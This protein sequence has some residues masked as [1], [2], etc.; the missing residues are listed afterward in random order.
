MATG[1]PSG[2]ESGGSILEA[3]VPG[4]S[5]IGRPTNPLAKC[6]AVGEPASRTPSELLQ[7]NIFFRSVQVRSVVGPTYPLAKC[8]AVGELASR[9]PS[10]FP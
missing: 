6:T 3:V 1:A 9:I 5:R 10:G 4:R 8:T 7:V 2:H